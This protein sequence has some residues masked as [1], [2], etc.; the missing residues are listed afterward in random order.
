MKVGHVACGNDIA[1]AFER[2]GGNTGIFQIGH[3]QEMC[4]CDSAWVKRQEG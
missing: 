4:G 1:A 3:L 2:R